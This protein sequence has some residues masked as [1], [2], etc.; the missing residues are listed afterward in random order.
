[1]TRGL[2]E[3]RDRDAQQMK[4]LELTVRTLLK[5]DLRVYTKK[6]RQNWE[7]QGDGMQEV[8]GMA[9]VFQEEKE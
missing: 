1:M 8:M 4:N 2:H 7:V 9:R 5:Q 3:D 6:S